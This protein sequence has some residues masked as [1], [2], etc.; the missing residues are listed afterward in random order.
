MK[1]DMEQFFKQSMVVL[2]TLRAELRITQKV[3]RF[4]PKVWPWIA[5]ERET[6]C[7]GA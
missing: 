6:A 3:G 4:L 5:R 2:L 7:K 1:L